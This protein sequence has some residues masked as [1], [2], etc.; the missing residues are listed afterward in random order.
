[1][2]ERSRVLVRRFASR[3]H[4]PIG[5]CYLG[6]ELW[7]QLGLAEFFA[8]HLDVDGPMYHGRV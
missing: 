2:I 6:L 8:Q 5:D 3:A 7:K 1:M 4:A